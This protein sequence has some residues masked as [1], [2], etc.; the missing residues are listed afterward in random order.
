MTDSDIQELR[1]RME[2]LESRVDEKLDVIAA[3]LQAISTTIASWRGA[4]QAI[5]VLVALAVPILGGLMWLIQ[6]GGNK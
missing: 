6:H 1:K 5:A 4:Q 3:E 2:K